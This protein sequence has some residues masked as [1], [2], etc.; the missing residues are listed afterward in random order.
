MEPCS[1][2]T[3]GRDCG[4]FKAFEVAAACDQQGLFF[5]RELKH[6]IMGE[7]F[8]VSLDLLVQALCGHPIQLGQVGVYDDLFAAYEQD[9]LLDYADPYYLILRGHR[10]SHLQEISYEVVAFCDHLL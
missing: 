4:K 5:R 1:V 10:A 9:A 7:A 2:K 3:Y 6:E 8:F